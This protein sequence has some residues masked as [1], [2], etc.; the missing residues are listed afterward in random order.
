MKHM[1]PGGSSGR[2]GWIVVTALMAAAG[3]PRGA[4][5]QTLTT[6]AGFNGA[7]GQSPESSLVADAT[8]NLFG[9]TAYGGTYGYGTVFEIVK[10]SGG[11]ASAP[12]TLVNFDRVHG[13]YPSGGLIMDANGDLLG[14]T[15]DGGSGAEESGVGTVFEIVKTSGGYAGTPT[16]LVIFDTADGANPYGNLIADAAG[17][18][19]GTTEAGGA[20][21]YG[22]VFE[23]A[24]TAG[25]YAA[26]PTVLF[27][28]DGA[29]G[30][31]PSGNLMADANGNLFGSTT[32]GGAFGDGTVF[33][34]A[35]TAGGYAGA[36]TTLVSFHNAVGEAPSGVSADATGN[37]FGTTQVGGANGYG[38]VFEITK[39]SGG[40]ASDPTTLVNFGNLTYPNG[41][42]VDAAGNLFGTTN[43]TS[44]VFEVANTP[45]GYAG[46]TTLVS[47]NGADGA[48]PYGSLIADGA[49]N[50]V[51]TTSYAGPSGWGTVFEVTSSGYVTGNGATISKLTASENPVAHGDNVTLTAT[52]SPATATGSV[53]FYD[54]SAP[55][56][57]GVIAGGMASFL[58]KNPSVGTH[59]VTAAAY[60]GAVSPALM[61]V[62]V[63]EPVPN[64]PIPDPLT[65]NLLLNPGAESGTQDWWPPAPMSAVTAPGHTGSYSF[66]GVSVPGA[67]IT[68]G[69]NLAQVTGI[70]L[71]Q[72]DSGNLSANYSF[73]FAD[74]S[75]GSGSYGQVTL[76]FLDGNSIPL[77]QGL[78]GI[79]RDAGTET[80]SNGTGSFPI[81]P[82]TRRINYTMDFVT[83]KPVNTGL[84]D[85]N[86]LTI[87]SQASTVTK[88][89]SSENP[90]VNGDSVTLTATVSP[91][92]ATGIVTFYDGGDTLG[93]GALSNGAASLVFHN[94]SVGTHLL[95]AAYGGDLADL[96]ST[97][98]V[99][100]EVDLEPETPIS[101]SMT[102]LTSNL[103]LN[104]GAES[105]TSGWWPPAPA[106]EAVAPA[107]TGSFSFQGTAVPGAF[108]T[109][110]VD[111]T[112]VP[113]LSLALL[114][115][116]ELAA[117]YSF[118]FADLSPGS[119]A[120]GQ[121]TL[122]FLDSNGIPLGEGLSAPLRDTGSLAWS[123]G[124]GAFPIPPGTRRI[125][126]TMD[127]I[128]AVSVNTGLIDDNLLTIGLI[129]Q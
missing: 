8:G 92:T 32:D 53:T 14:T 66:Q 2:L 125:N 107:H 33:E 36:P 85:D 119:G 111:L 123:N 112:Q 37:L 82:G 16:T 22:T 47:L 94:P 102:L 12:L 46:L 54:D 62:D 90:A 38:T 104:P 101:P 68:Q 7:D 84:I 29:D 3:E 105:G 78:S 64:P 55:L 11:Y 86:V 57:T 52:V 58:F 4:S 51:G 98:P 18:L 69:V 63:T 48:N 17:N 25:G 108:I 126:Y 115:R 59:L 15:V 83:A 81:P 40:Y 89:V 74:L 49:G 31:F 114:D 67:F 120:Y 41:V 6:L 43:W 44:T 19:F 91:S 24:R 116:A 45:G 50:L 21:G 42:I 5:A 1:K 13:A 113:G 28:F 27:S 110:G 35:R 103:L 76:T 80:W 9:T 95:T 100:T 10:T 60:G 72:V 87:S 34:I 117:N 118:W 39:T 88:L 97:S 79:L 61:L 96:R 124:M 70:T 122:T 73:W 30:A 20:S 65:G 128:T 77:G 99:L 109:Q 121:I 129:G 106:S 56:G 26:T 75:P 71:A 93:T 23:I 127:F